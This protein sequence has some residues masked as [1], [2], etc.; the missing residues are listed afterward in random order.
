MTNGN[1]EL[2]NIFYQYVTGGAE[3]MPSQTLYS[4]G[5]M[6]NACP[7]PH[8]PRICFRKKPLRGGLLGVQSLYGLHARQAT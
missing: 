7:D 6:L 8:I 3:G 4:L 1:V 2:K 5:A